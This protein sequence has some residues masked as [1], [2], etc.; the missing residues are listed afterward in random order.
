MKL[1]LAIVF[2]L[3]MFNIIAFSQIS[4]HYGSPQG[5]YNTMLRNNLQKS[6][7]AVRKANV[8]LSLEE[9]KLAGV[10]RNY[11]KGYPNGTNIE[12]YREEYL[13][14]L[15]EKDIYL[16]FKEFNNFINEA[17]DPGLRNSTVKSYQDIFALIRGKEYDNGYDR[18]AEQ[19]FK[20]WVRSVENYWGKNA[21]GLSDVN[22][23]YKSL[24]ANLDSY[25][26]FIEVRDKAEYLYRNPLSPLNSSDP[27]T[28]Y[29]GLMLASGLC[30]DLDQ[31][32]DFYQQLISVFSEQEIAGGVSAYRRQYPDRDSRYFAKN[33][34]LHSPLQKIDWLISKNDPSLYALYLIKR[35][36][37]FP[38]AWTKI[39]H[40]NRVKRYGADKVKDILQ[41]V[42]QNAGNM[43]FKCVGDPDAMMNLRFG[44]GKT[45]RDNSIIISADCVAQ[46]LG[47]DVLWTDLED[48]PLSTADLAKAKQDLINDLEKYQPSNKQLNI[49]TSA[50]YQRLISVMNESVLLRAYYFQKY[51]G[52][53]LTL[54]DSGD[55]LTKVFEEDQSATDFFIGLESLLV[56][57]A[58]LQKNYA[59]IAAAMFSKDYGHLSMERY[60]LAITDFLELEFQHG[61]A[62]VLE[63]I[64]SMKIPPLEPFYLGIR[65]GL[66]IHAGQSVK[67]H[68][69][70]A[71]PA[72]QKEIANLTDKYKAAFAAYRPSD[73]SG[74]L[75]Y[76]SD[77]FKIVLEEGIEGRKQVTALIFKG[78]PEDNLTEEKE[79]RARHLEL[80]KPVLESKGI[81]PKTVYCDLRLEGYHIYSGQRVA[82]TPVQNGIYDTSAWNK[83][84]EEQKKAL[85][86]LMA[87]DAL[88]E[89]QRKFYENEYIARE[90]PIVRCI[91]TT[92]ST[93]DIVI[94]FTDPAVTSLNDFKRKHGYK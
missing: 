79:F 33:I 25:I 47:Q 39:I 62:T 26:E 46:Q 94:K 15:F 69:V 92:I 65:S 19:H 29:K 84:I 13:D 14:R 64:E 71:D 38:W 9:E 40:Q 87:K 91:I 45:G 43:E 42:W 54:G 6:F 49:S 16:L 35:R 8:A 24:E 48:F 30:L 50:R 57:L 5:I 7:E 10:R 59:T 4:S 31:C 1:M 80:I 11:W 61:R 82:L 23:F 36:T 28:W 90:R 21:T 67:K 93:G 85:E 18:I 56:G 73:Y 81:N 68:F 2:N 53:A 34:Y 72:Y 41:Q 55:L 60:E 27:I 37:N 52:S 66:W 58:N 88:T 20:R 32:K 83:I 63:Q 44:A 70:R 86:E 75:L 3:S 22:T 76:E 74:N 89:S 12:A 17:L 78:N 51:Y 77:E